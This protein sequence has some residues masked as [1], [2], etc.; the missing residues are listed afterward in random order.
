MTAYHPGRN[1]NAWLMPT[2]RM[3]VDFGQDEPLY[4]INRP[5]QSDNP[6]SSHYD[7]GINAWRKGEYIHMPFGEKAVEKAYP[8]TLVL[9][10]E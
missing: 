5:G 7:D 3:I 6:A 2:M 8:R 9:K 1:F 4:V 10:P